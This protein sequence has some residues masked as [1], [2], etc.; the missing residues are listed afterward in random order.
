VHLLASYTI[1]EMELRNELNESHYTNE[2]KIECKSHRVFKKDT[3]L[4]KFA[5]QCFS[6]KHCM[7]TSYLVFKPSSSKTKECDYEEI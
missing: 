4:K 5:Q 3:S 7:K 1:S 2:M 6:R